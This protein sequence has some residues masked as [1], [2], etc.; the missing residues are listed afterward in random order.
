[1]NAEPKAFAGQR[2]RTDE[3]SEHKLAEL[4]ERVGRLMA[5]HDFL[6]RRSEQ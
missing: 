4:Y 1:M 5:E 3:G 2:D 6:L